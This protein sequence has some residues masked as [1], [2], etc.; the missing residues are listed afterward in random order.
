MTD[1]QKID[2][3]RRLIEHAFST[4]KERIDDQ[5]DFNHKYEKLFKE[6]YDKARAIAFS[7]KEAPFLQELMKAYLVLYEKYQNNRNNVRFYKSDQLFQ[8]LIEQSAKVSDPSLFETWAGHIASTAVLVS[9]HNRFTALDRYFQRE[10]TNFIKRER[11]RRRS[12]RSLIDLL[13]D[14]YARTHGGKQPS[15]AELE[16]FDPRPSF[17]GLIDI[18]IRTVQRRFV[19]ALEKGTD[20]NLDRFAKQLETFSEHLKTVGDED[21][22]R[23]FQTFKLVRDPPYAMDVYLRTLYYGLHAIVCVQLHAAA[24]RKHR[25]AKTLNGLTPDDIKF[26]VEPASRSNF[27]YRSNIVQALTGSLRQPAVAIGQVTV[28]LNTYLMAEARYKGKLSLLQLDETLVI[29]KKWADIKEMGEEISLAA[30]RKDLPALTRILSDPRNAGALQTM[31]EMESR[32]LQLSDGHV[33]GTR[34][35]KAGSRIKGHPVLGTIAVTFI[36]VGDVVYVELGPF[37]PLMFQASHEFITDRLFAEKIL[38]IYASTIGMVVLMRAIF[39][40]MGFIPALVSGGI[41]GLIYAVAE[42]FAIGWLQEQVAEYVDPNL[43]I[44]LGIVLSLFGPRPPTSR[45]LKT[46]MVEPPADRSLLSGVVNPNARRA[47][48]AVDAANSR[49]DA[50]A[51]PVFAPPKPPA[52][53]TPPAIRKPDLEPPPTPTPAAPAQKPPSAPSEESLVARRI[54]AESRLGT[55][56]PANELDVTLAQTAAKNEEA[57]VAELATGTGGRTVTTPESPA[58]GTVTYQP[59]ATKAPTRADIRFTQKQQALGGRLSSTAAGGG[60]A[61]GLN[62][63]SRGTPTTTSYGRKEIEMPAQK[64][65]GLNADKRNYIKRAATIY[66]E[67]MS[68]QN[69]KLPIWEQSTNAHVNTLRRLRQEFPDVTEH[70]QPFTGVTGPGSA[71]GPNVRIADATYVDVNSPARARTPADFNVELKLKA[72]PEKGGKVLRVSGER[73]PNVT[74]DQIQAYEVGQTQLGVPTY[75]VNAR[76]NIYAF[77]GGRWIK[78]GGPE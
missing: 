38:E 62:T 58:G 32:K 8:L 21:L 36:G 42:Y 24:V 30:R 70:G 78:V 29:Q 67:E 69:N 23:L 57:M 77:K 47:D 61:R 6:E 45:K 51:N 41:V 4:V 15:A 59:S 50:V 14:E 11:E 56:R 54:W 3:F 27:L 1:K 12:Q 20:E 16:G 44:A 10:I 52:P 43:A 5:V 73:D 28:F 68:A 26:F 18:R 76:G 25:Y 64:G 72:Y 46:D 74:S 19:D 65:D 60:P 66:R 49:A 2:Q 55:R 37:K 75:V 7:A 17:T 34:V 22:L 35:L 33:L 39:T 63:G 48:G 53:A 71:S 13:R 9:F 40:A 31:R